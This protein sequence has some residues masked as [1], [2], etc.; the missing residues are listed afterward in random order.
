MEGDNSVNARSSR[1]ALPTL[2]WIDAIR[3]RGKKLLGGEG[4]ASS[5][6]PSA[7]TT[8]ATPR[9]ATNSQHSTSTF[10]SSLSVSPTTRP[11]STASSDTTVSRAPA[12]PSISSSRDAGLHGLER[13]MSRLKSP[14]KGEEMDVE[15]A[16]A[17]CGGMKQEQE[18]VTSEARHARA[19]VLALG[20]SQA[21]NQ[22][23]IR[24]DQSAATAVQ[25]SALVPQSI[26]P[27][28][29]ALVPLPV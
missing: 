18:Q 15:V 16:E 14:T 22:L 20:N 4:A 25:S 13:K 27:L 17:S 7:T 2:S 3:A 9:G 21:S 8:F 19:R 11:L 29:S 26:V 1:P 23:P 10:G 24:L 12:Q 28:S 6:T 5:P